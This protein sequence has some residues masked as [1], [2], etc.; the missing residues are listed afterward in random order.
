MFA[1][2][3]DQG[4][5]RGPEIRHELCVCVCVCPAGSGQY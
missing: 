2:V 4:G 5:M 1:C 3:T